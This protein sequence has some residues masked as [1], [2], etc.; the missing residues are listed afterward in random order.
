MAI[1]RSVT[2]SGPPRISGPTPTPSGGSGAAP[3][4]GA[5]HA[6]IGHV[7]DEDGL[8][9]ETIAYWFLR[10]GQAYVE[11]TLQ[12]GGGQVVARVNVADSYEVFNF[13]DRV[14]LIACNGDPNAAM[15]VG[16]LHDDND[17]LPAS[18]AGGS[19][20]VEGPV[21]DEGTNARFARRVQ[22]IQSNPNTVFVLETRGSGDIVA[23]SGAGVLIKAAGGY[24]LVDG[25]HIVLGAGPEV[26]A[27]PETVVGEEPA[28]G[29]PMLPP[30]P[31][32]GG[33]LTE[34]PYE[35]IAHGLVRASDPYQSN[36]AI[37][38]VFFTYVTALETLVAAL[39]AIPAISAAAA[40]ALAAFQAVPKPT[41]ITSA[42]MSAAQAVSA[43]R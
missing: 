17:P 37:D 26:A 27:V 2:T 22:F 21:F 7:V 11:C 41:S 24:V 15:I 6:T 32:P 33:N 9:D 14:S 8:P 3:M 12:P 19:I 20:P 36:A 38:P 42:A 25:D 43:P 35:G 39:A 31:E 5:M 28:P 18:V 34:P 16:K 30:I 40:P 13:G 29:A 4:P 23:H 10:G 1:T